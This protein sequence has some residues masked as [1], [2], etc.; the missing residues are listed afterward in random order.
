MSQLSETDYKSNLK[1]AFN[2]TDKESIVRV[3]DY[4]DFLN[5]KN[6]DR[7]SIMTYLYQIREKYDSSNPCTFSISP[8]SKTMTP[9]NK[10]SKDKNIYNNNTTRANSTEN[11]KLYM[12][13]NKGGSVVYN[14]Q[15]KNS[16]F[17]PFDSEDDELDREKIQEKKKGI[18]EINSEN[19]KTNNQKK[20]TPEKKVLINF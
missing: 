8:K 13:T 2:A 6:L 1:Q 12:N 15:I 16:F 18:I 10:E 9:L 4:A 3:V 20:Q 11:K 7:L 14:Q 5:Q 17:N 19:S